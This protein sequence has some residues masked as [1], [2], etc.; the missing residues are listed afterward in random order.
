MFLQLFRDFAENGVILHKALV[1]WHTQK[2]FRI[3]QNN[4]FGIYLKAD[5]SY[6]IYYEKHKS[7]SPAFT[8]RMAFLLLSILRII[9]LT[10]HL[11]C[12]ARNLLEHGNKHALRG[13]TQRGRDHKIGQVGI[14]E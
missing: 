2:P 4:D 11:W 6:D 7:H 14:S 5:S 10:V 9:F 1:Y 12:H 13:E 8:W 3:S